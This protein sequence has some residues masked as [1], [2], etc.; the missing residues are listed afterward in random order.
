MTAYY[1]DLDADYLDKTGIDNT[2]NQYLGIGGFWAAMYGYGA[3]TALAPGDTLYI[4]GSAYTR[5]LVQL[6]TGS[7]NSA[8]WA[9]GDEVQN[10]SGDGDDWTGVICGINGT[11]V[12]VELDSACKLADIATADGIENTTRSDTDTL[13]AAIN[14]AP[15]L[16]AGS[17]GSASGY[18][19][20]IGVNASWSQDGTLAVFD[21]SDVNYS[22]WGSPLVILD[23]Y[24][25]CKYLRC[26]N[27][28]R[29]ALSIGGSLH[30]NDFECCE[31][32]N[33]GGGL[34]GQ[35]GFGCYVTRCL[36]KN[37]SSNGVQGF[38]GGCVIQYCTIVG[39]GGNGLYFNGGD[40]LARGCVIHD[41]T[42]HGVHDAHLRNKYI[43]CVI[44][45][46]NNGINI[47]GGGRQVIAECRLTNNTGYGLY[48]ND[49]A[50]RLVGTTACYA[51]GN[52]SANYHN[53]AHAPETLASVEDQGDT[54]AGYVDSANDD[55][56]L[57]E[58][59][60]MRS[61]AVELP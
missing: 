45:G 28:N 41:N 11:T 14:V 4:K 52:G 60:T 26:T 42:G 7:D 27:S 13:S 49:K 18:T 38:N 34:G 57:A 36:M 35:G 12:Y 44:D 56:N 17:G 58:G 46:N 51:Q 30:Y 55:F 5:R 1:C 19:K 31:F 39:N 16:P 21:G 32:L 24:T 43:G 10:D 53:V 9:E 54:D 25:Y 23:S 48:I 3:A 29:S 50:A 6:T 47:T 40:N 22:L 2:G 20:L 15:G 33:S 61:V 8:T 37:N 59:A